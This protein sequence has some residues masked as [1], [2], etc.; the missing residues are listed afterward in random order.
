M[1]PWFITGLV[2]AEDSFTVSVL[3]SGRFYYCDGSFY[4]IIR[5]SKLNKIPRTDIGFSI[6]QH[7]REKLLLEK[8]ITYFNCGRVKKDSKNSVHYYVVTN[9]K[10]ITDKILP[11]FNKYNTKGVK[12]INFVDWREGA[13]IIKTKN[14]LSSIGVERLRTIQSKMN[15]KRF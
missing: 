9:V 1:D 7:S 3:K 4:L 14:H 5:A 8:F 13:E 11:F 12:Y 10:D 2:D 6:A 15:S